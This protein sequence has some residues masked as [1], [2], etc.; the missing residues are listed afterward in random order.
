MFEVQM[1]TLSGWENCWF[2]YDLQNNRSPA[3][4]RCYDEAEAEIQELIDE[5]E[6]GYLREE[7]R[8]VPAT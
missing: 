6:P 3:R 8:I 1:L 4:F 7:F 5:P 2:D